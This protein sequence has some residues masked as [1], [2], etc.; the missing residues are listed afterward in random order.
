MAAAVPIVLAIG[1]GAGWWGASRLMSTAVAPAYRASLVFLP[2]N[3]S[4]A[5]VAPTARFAISPDGTQLVF[6]GTSNGVNRLW[7]RSLNDLTARPLADLRGG[8]GGA[9]FWSPDG[10]RVGFFSNGQLLWVATSGGAPTL[11]AESP[12]FRQQMPPGAWNA[13]GV[14]VVSSG[15]TLARVPANGG[16]LVP[17]TTL[18]TAAGETFHTFPHFLPDGQHLLYTAYKSLTPVAVYAIS[19]DRPLERQK[20]M[21]GGSNVQYADR[22]LLYLRENAL[23]AQPFDPARRTLSGEPAV[24]ADGV[25]ANIAVHFG[26]AFSTS[27]TGVL[28][29]QGTGAGQSLD[30]PFGSTTL[31]WRTASGTAQTLID[32]PATHRH[33]SIAPDGRR[34]LVT[35]FD[36]RGRTDL[37]TIDLARGVRTRVSLTLQ[38]TQLSGAVWSAD[39]KAFIVNLG[40]GLGLDLYRKANDST[41]AEVLLLAD[42][43]SKLPLSISPDGRFLLFDTV[44]AETGGDIWVLPLNPPAKAA[45][46]VSTPYFERFAQFSPDGKWVAYASDDSG[47]TE[48]YVRGFPGGHPQVAVS[49]AGGDVPRWSR[50]GSQLFFYS[51][52]KMMAA[53]VKATAATLEV[54][55]VTPLFDCR[56]P[57][58]FRRLFYDVMPDGR[59]LMMTP[60]GDGLPTSLTLTVNW[61]QLRQPHR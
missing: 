13:D 1:I 28:V 49:A 35:T 17:L 18:D 48:I 5:Q 21:D 14:I 60:R 23:V 31:A 54:T 26:G 36:A 15:G 40:K 43:R 34:A 7:L 59:F 56:P 11:I 32:E 4:L 30:L 57:E 12:A 39:G 10:N 42:E 50:D 27:R 52:G 3:A 46:F 22:T 38:P 47:A 8:G 9:P 41:G 25:V 45:P 24:I 55:S 29:H 58:G 44:S 6:V 53:T 33:L 51:N 61:P 2:R 37:W 16:K 20:V 19:L